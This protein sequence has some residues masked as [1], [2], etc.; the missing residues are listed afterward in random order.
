MN[1]FFVVHKLQASFD[2]HQFQASFEMAAPLCFLGSYRHGHR[3]LVGKENNEEKASHRF[4]AKLPE[5]DLHLN[6]K[7]KLLGQRRD[8]L[9][10]IGSERDLHS[11]VSILG[12]ISI[13][14]GVCVCVCVC[15]CVGGLQ[16]LTPTAFAHWLYLGKPLDGFTISLTPVAEFSSK[17]VM[18][19]A[20]R[21]VRANRWGTNRAVREGL[22]DTQKLTVGSSMI[23]WPT[24]HEASHFVD[25]DVLELPGDL[26]VRATPVC[27]VVA[28]LAALIMQGHWREIVCYGRSWNDPFKWNWPHADWL[29]SKCDL[30]WMPSVKTKP[31]GFNDFV[32][33]A[34]QLKEWSGKIVQD[35]N[36]D[37]TDR[38][39]LEDWVTRLDEYPGSTRVYEGG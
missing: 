29:E 32:A 5:D 9:M 28:P 31:L 14:P 25:D 13:R 19:T 23:V 21:E 11:P 12:V 6:S 8:D 4:R 18:T 24:V 10:S 30:H 37:D 38:M 16:A 27:L 34:N 35:D 15:V 3:R 1:D 36:D 33:L 2:V 17:K 39:A 7:L 22:G 26:D 20:P